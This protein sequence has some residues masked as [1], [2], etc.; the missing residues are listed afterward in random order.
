MVRLLEVSTVNRE[1]LDDIERALRSDLGMDLAQDKKKDAHNYMADLIGRVNSDTEARL[2]GSL[3]SVSPEHA[4]MVRR[5]MFTF[6]DLVR[7]AGRQFRRYCRSVTNRVSP[8]A[9]SS[10]MSPP[11]KS[12]FPTCPSAKPKCSARSSSLAA[13]PTRLRSKKHRRK[14]CFW[15][16]RS[17]LQACS[18]S[19]P[20]VRRNRRSSNSEQ[21]VYC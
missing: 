1:I 9:S 6:A 20:R 19:K 3:E 10:R 16:R 7:V 15:R 13:H 11:A 18:R 17:L 14:S 2:L 12:F 8:W 5:H 4:A 21:C